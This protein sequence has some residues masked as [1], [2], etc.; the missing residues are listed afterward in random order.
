MYLHIYHIFF[1][2]SSVREH[3]GYF[4]IWGIVISAALNTA[5]LVSWKV[6]L[7]NIHF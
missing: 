5:V 2:H 6:F 3:L 7:F 1:I 4:H